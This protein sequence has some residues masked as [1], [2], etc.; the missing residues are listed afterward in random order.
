MSRVYFYYLF[1]SYLQ[2][3]LLRWKTY[4]PNKSKFWNVLD[5]LTLNSR[6]LWQIFSHPTPDGIYTLVDQAP[7]KLPLF[8]MFCKYIC[9]RQKLLQFSSD[10]FIILLNAYGALWCKFRKLVHR[11][12]S[13]LIAKC[14]IS[15]PDFL[16]V[17]RFVLS[18]F[19]P[20]KS[21]RIRVRGD[22]HPLV[23]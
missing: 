14:S 4:C 1:S 16:L 9:L 17:F 23:H 12:M 7:K 6:Q 19:L 10:H 22:H 18:H 20:L 13:L 2:Q 8:T 21:D 15:S 3:Y 11:F 5:T